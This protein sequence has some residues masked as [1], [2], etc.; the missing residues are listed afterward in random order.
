MVSLGTMQGALL[1]TRT[2]YRVI[3][4]S[5]SLGNKGHKHPTEQ[6]GLHYRS[7]LGLSAAYQSHPYSLCNSN[8]VR[9][10]KNGFHITLLENRPKIQAK[11]TTCCL[12]R[13]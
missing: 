1:E 2:L 8:S 5:R 11:G 13:Y 7:Q 12:N 9:F 3:L 10:S 6:T 4:H